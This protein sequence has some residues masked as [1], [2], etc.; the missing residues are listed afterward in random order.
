LGAVAGV[1]GPFGS[2]D[3]P[4]PVRLGYWL[5]V[6][7]GSYALG[8]TVAALA[9]EVLRDRLPRWATL[10]A[11][12]LAPGAPVAALVI[13][14]DGVAFGFGPVSLLEALAL[15]GYCTAISLG[16]VGGTLLLETQRPPPPVT[17][18]GPPRLLLRLPHPK[19]GRLLH[20][21]MADHYVEVT[22]DRGTEF[23]LL[24]M[25]DAVAETAGVQGLRVHRSHWVALDAVRRVARQ[26]GRVVL[27]LETGAEVPVSRSC[28]PAARAAG[29][30][31]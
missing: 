11:A 12:G 30:A 22:T 3:R 13:L 9:A 5:L 2:F 28:L 14:I 7:A 10:L 29:L 1:V 17:A 19:R 8:A 20:L 18:P 31:A 6:A 15:A 24:R 26:G 16:V 23:V 27:V 25:S 21:R 4:L